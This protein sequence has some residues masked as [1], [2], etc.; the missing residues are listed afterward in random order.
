[1]KLRYLLAVSL[2]FPAIAHA[3][4]LDVHDRSELRLGYGVDPLT[5][6]I[7]DQCIEFTS[8]DVKPESG[9]FESEKFSSVNTPVTVEHITSMDQMSKYSSSS[10]SGSVSYTS[11][12]ASMSESTT[13]ASSM[14]SDRAS[15]GL[16]MS[17]DYGRRYITNV[18][19]KPYY[20]ELFKTD[21]EKFYELCGREYVAGYKLGQGLRVLMSV[22]ASSASSYATLNRSIGAAVQYGGLG[23]GISG[24]FSNASSSLMTSS[25]LEVSLYAY[26][27]GPLKSVS[28]IV[29]TESDANQFRALLSSYVDLMTPDLAVKTH[30]ITMPYFLY[31]S[32]G[33]PILRETQRRVVRSLYSDFLLLNDHL[34]R[35]DNS[36]RSN[37]L[38]SYIG[39]KVCDKYSDQCDNYIASIKL[40]RDETESAIQEVE[41][42]FHQCK[43]AEKV[44]DC[45]TFSEIHTMNDMLMKIIWPNH[46]RYKM[47]QTY[48][49]EIKNR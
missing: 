44:S 7:F 13:N 33:G 46:F 15:V 11:V 16:D 26:G 40:Y 4:I 20:E 17:A 41:T 25:A 8:A 22:S 49:E 31:E 3:T 23:A 5:E 28:Q 43:N 35:L 48:L 39:N 36:L 2:V 42:L 12:S 18:N 27:A 45:K 10:M 30:Y 29:K 34:K 24:A 32:G 9:I 21:K 19:V 1:M 6:Q 47:L 14:F 38:R 37:S